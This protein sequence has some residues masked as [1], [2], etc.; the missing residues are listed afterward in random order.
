[1][2]HA[3]HWNPILSFSQSGNPLVARGH[4]A[5]LD[6]TFPVHDHTAHRRPRAIGRAKRIVRGGGHFCVI[7]ALELCSIPH[8]RRCRAEPAVLWCSILVRKLRKQQTLHQENANLRRQV[9][10]RYSLP[11]IIAHSRAMQRVLELVQRVAPTDATVLLQGESGTGK[12]VIAK[13]LHH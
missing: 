2:S 4:K 13:A 5:L 8:Q 6:A 9:R 7:P 3:R 11:G 12:E 1:M 10:E